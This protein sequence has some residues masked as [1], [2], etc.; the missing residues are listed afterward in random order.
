MLAQDPLHI[1][2][3]PPLVPGGVKPLDDWVE[4]DMHFTGPEGFSQY[5]FGREGCPDNGTAYLKFA[6]GPRQTLV[7]EPL[8]ST[9]FKLISVDLAEYSTRFRTHKTITFVGHKTN[10]ATVIGEF[11]ID[12]VIDGTGPLVDFETFIF[13][14]EFSNL[15]Y[16]EIPTTG[17]SMDNMV[18][19][20]GPGF[21]TLIDL[22][23]TGP[24]QVVEGSLVQ[25]NTVVSY[26]NGFKLNVTTAT[27][28]LIQPEIYGE[29]DDSG[30]L[31]TKNIDEPLCITLYAKYTEGPATLEAEKIV[32]V[33]PARTIHVPSEY[34][35]I[36][37]AIDVARDGDLIIVADGTYIGSGNRNIDFRGKAITVR[38]ENGPENCIIDCNGTQWRP[39]RG[40]RFHNYEGLDSILT[41]FTITRGYTRSEG[42]GIYCRES[43]PTISNCLLIDNYAYQSGGAI[44]CWKSDATINECIIMSNTAYSGGGICCSGYS[45]PTISNCVI[46]NN[47]AEGAS[48]IYC[49]SDANII[50]CL[51]IRN[52]AVVAGGIGVGGWAF[53]RIV[54]CTFSG[55]SATWAGALYCSELSW[56]EVVNSIFWSNNAEYGSEI[57][58]CNIDWGSSLSV[59]YTNI[60]DG[61]AGIYRGHTSNTRLYWG[62]RNIDADPCFVEPG[63]WDSN[64][65]WVEGD[66]HLL[67]TSPCVDAGT[68]ANNYSDIEGNI[69]PYDFPGVDNNGE[70][71]EFD[72]GAYELVPVEAKM[73]LTPQTLNCS[74]KGKW[75]KAH[76]TLPEGFYPEDVDV[77][78][79]AIAYPMEAESEYITGLGG[80][81]GPVRLEV[82]F[83]REAFCNSITE[84]DEAD[85]TVIGSLMND[86]YFYAIDTIRIIAE[87]P[88]RRGRR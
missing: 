51:I 1:T 88:P 15:S 86:R 18:I 9:P 57:A 13:G 71:P 54:N 74:G 16:V 85:I 58:M 87:R 79:P 7:F 50:N 53:P 12:G 3:D 65:V 31:M 59:S 77:N 35:N 55:N 46:A 22:E 82:V 68:D 21:T 66:Y 14:E 45:K 25:Y 11:I 76:I 2:F 27:I 47:R 78:E 70:L 48:G 24:E 56:P 43:S 4:E 20:F 41:G 63:Y 52:N 72:M 36:Q 32:Q 40:F 84:I 67:R 19:A 34:E 10:G 81:K 73:Q 64:G 33:L 37:S 80:D 28:L 29:I 8:Y 26:S 38:S 62:P 6:S 5:D 61:K 60:Q 49:Q 23:I 17:Y 44:D 30:M 42:G 83:G 69:R 75:V 39:Y